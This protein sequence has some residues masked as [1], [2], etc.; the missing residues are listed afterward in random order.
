[1]AMNEDMDEL[2][3]LYRHASNEAP[4]ARLD[5]RILGAADRV[6][7]RRQWSRR[8]AWPVAI[9]AS[10]LLLATWPAPGHRSTPATDPMAAH[11]AGR[12]RSEL[13]QMDVT[14]PRNEVDQFLLTTNIHPQP[15]A[16]NAL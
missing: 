16:G 13:Q 12:V 14:P 11:D 9:A 7:L 10:L 6:A 4:A 8:I 5:A 3:K 1:M 15:E 2:L